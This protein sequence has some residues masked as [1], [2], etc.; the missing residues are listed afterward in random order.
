HVEV[1]EP[2]TYPSN[3]P[4]GGRHY[5]Q[6]LPAG[7]YD[8]DNLPNLPGDLEGYI[9]HSLEHGYII[10]WYNCSLLNETACTELKTEIQSVMD[11]RNNFKLIAFPWNSIDVPL[12]MTSWGRLQ[13]FEQFNSALALNFIDANR[14]KSPEPNAP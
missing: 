9:V 7:F 12:V 10:F 8:E 4:A 1:G 11:S 3:P 5:A 6:S 13:Q 14:N 2:L